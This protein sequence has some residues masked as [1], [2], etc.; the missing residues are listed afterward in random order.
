MSRVIG[1]LMVIG[2]HITLSICHDGYID[3]SRLTFACV[4][5]DAVGIFWLILGFFLFKNTSY[6]RLLKKTAINIGIPTVVFSCF[7]FFFG[8][9][10]VE[11]VSLRES[12][13]HTPGEYLD[14]LKG[15]MKW[16]S[17]VKYGAHLWYNYVYILIILI[18]PVLKSFVQYLNEKVK[19]E[20]IFMTATF[21]A[22]VLNDITRNQLFEFSH[23]SINAL[24]PAA[25]IVLWGYIL[26]KH[27]ETLATQRNLILS[28]LTFIGLNVF[29]IILQ[30]YSYRMGTGNHIMFWYSGIGLLCASCIVIFAFCIG[31]KLQSTNLIQKGI[32]FLSEH[33]FNIYLVHFFVIYILN[34]LSFPIVLGAYI[35]SDVLFMF[36]HTIT[37]FVISLVVSMVVK[38]IGKIVGLLV[39]RRF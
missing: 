17:P 4:V 8:E 37:V 1:C 13:V 26:Y 33:T 21:G 9:W 22:F 27:K 28:V 25:I 16:N 15:L 6:R 30:F 32:L 14:V 5:A 31:D 20:Q 36:T 7:A 34:R 38:G 10:I 35:Q 23:H 24:I 3:V 39:H 18:F 11:G 19:R 12:I 2:I 29:R